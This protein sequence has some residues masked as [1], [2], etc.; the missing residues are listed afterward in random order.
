[1]YGNIGARD[2]LDFT[3]IGGSVN[4]VARVEALCKEAGAPLLLTESFRNAVDRTDLLKVGRFQLRGVSA[5]QDIFTV[6]PQ[7]AG[8]RAQADAANG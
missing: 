2:R 6:A 1:M 5:A 8:G 3:V 7:P 4:E